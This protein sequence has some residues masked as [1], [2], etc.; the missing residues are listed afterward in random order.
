MND[1]T[2]RTDGLCDSVEAADKNAT[3][4]AAAMSDDMSS[5]MPDKKTAEYKAEPVTDEARSVKSKVKAKKEKKASPTWKSIL[6]GAAIGLLLV[7]FFWGGYLTFYLSYGKDLQSLLFV[8]KTYKDHYYFEDGSDIPAKVLT[9]GLMDRY[10]EYYTAEEYYKEKQ[11]A[12]GSRQGYGLSFV[13]FLVYKVSGNS[14]AEKAG[15]KRGGEIVAYRFNDDEF[16]TVGKF[17]DFSS[18]LSKATAQDVLSL[19]VRYGEEY[20]TF[21]MKKA[22][23]RESYVR[24]TDSTGKYSFTDDGGAMELVRGGDMPSDLGLKPDW[25]YIEYSSFYGDVDGIYGSVGQFSCVLDK[26]IEN[27]KTKLIIDLRNN[28]GGYMSI[29]QKLSGLFC[30]KIP[31]GE[32][33]AQVAE[34]KN[35]NKRTF[36]IVDTYGKKSDGTLYADYLENIVFLAN[37]NSA[38]AS[39]ALIGAVLDY[40]KESGANCVRVVVD[41]SKTEAGATVYK[42]YGK[43]IM[44]STFEN[45]ATGEALKL[46]TARIYWPLSGTCIHDEGITPQ[47]DSRV[48]AAVG[49]NSVAYACS[50]V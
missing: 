17:A 48:F 23:Y 11:S 25:G 16:Q 47:T 6:R 39:E 27:G 50:L 19:R 3:N 45:P 21:S 26:M 41:G 18:A 37:E 13:D 44:Q 22:E 38:S 28:G 20:E 9:D 33:L 10:S 32:R 40:D 2:K 7:A 35:G 30:K 42:T 24:Y 15:L 46:T 31:S 43:G 5:D 14:P 36:G 34:Y 1:E 12:S 49:A 8:Y 4:A 29:L